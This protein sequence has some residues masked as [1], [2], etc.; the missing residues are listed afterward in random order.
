MW[1]AFLMFVFFGWVLLSSLGN[2]PSAIHD[3]A[4]Y[5]GWGIL[6]TIIGGVFVI[7]LISGLLLVW[8]DGGISAPTEFREQQRK[9]YIPPPE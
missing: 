8:F 4:G 1:I 6:A 7:M 5:Q 9:N 2:R 3:P